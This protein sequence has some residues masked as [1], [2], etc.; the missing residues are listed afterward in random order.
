MNKGN[1]ALALLI[2]FLGAIFLPSSGQSDAD[3]LVI[4]TH[5]SVSVDHMT[6]AEVRRVFLKERTDWKNGE[7]AFPIN[8]KPGTKARMLFQKKV[9]NMSDNE[10]T[11]YWQNQKIKR[12]LTP[13][14]E[15]TN[16]QRA[17]FSLKGSL[18]YCLKSEHKPGAS[19]IILTL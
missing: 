7:R 9:L 14:P 2:A 12:G 15:F 8:G 16:T 1:S 10:E 18:G 3:T 19:K 5:K 6:I 17:V 4:I 11:T 13:P